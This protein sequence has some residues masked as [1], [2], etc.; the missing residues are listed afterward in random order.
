M[1]YYTWTVVALNTNIG[2][3]LAGFLWKLM[4]ETKLKQKKSQKKSDFNPVAF[5]AIIEKRKVMS[6]HGSSGKKEFLHCRFQLEDY[7]YENTVMKPNGCF[8]PI[9][10]FSASVK[11]FW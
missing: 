4:S 1:Q 10:I 9:C 8:F 2:E 11:M 3:L 5:I 6:I 7:Q